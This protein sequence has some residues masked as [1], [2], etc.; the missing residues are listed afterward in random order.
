MIPAGFTGLIGERTFK[1]RTK[2]PTCGVVMRLERALRPDEVASLV[3]H[4]CE[5]TFR[6]RAP[7]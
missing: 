3:C 4:F 7:A 5:E 2:C 6:V 1:V